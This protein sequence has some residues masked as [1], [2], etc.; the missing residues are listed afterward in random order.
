MELE[1][2][3]QVMARF[4][5][6][7]GATDYRW[8]S[9]KDAI[10]PEIFP[11]CEPLSR[12]SVMTNSF[13]SLVCEQGGHLWLVRTFTQGID[14]VF[15]PIGTLEV[16]SIVSPWSLPRQHWIG[17][18]AVCAQMNER[19]RLAD[20]KFNIL[21]PPPKGEPGTPDEELLTRVRLG[22][23]VTANTRLAL[24]VI[25]TQPWRY[26]GVCFALRS[27]SESS[28]EVLP[29]LAP[30]F[31]INF[32]EVRL[33]S[34]QQA[35]QEAVLMRE[36]APAEWAVLDK[37]NTS[38]VQSALYWS[39]NPSPPVPI[40]SADDPLLDWLFAF[41]KASFQGPELL[42]RLRQDVAPYLLP[43]HLVRMI[44]PEL[45]EKATTLLVAIERGESLTASPEIIEE[46]ARSGYLSLPEVMPLQLWTEHVNRSPVVMEQFVRRFEALE[47]PRSTTLFILD[48]PLSN[49]IADMRFLES[50]EKAAH[51]ADKNGL[52]PPR[53]NV[54]LF[55]K[56]ISNLEH[57]WPLTKIEEL[58]GYWAKSILLMIHKMT[59]PKDGILT[60][61]E[62]LAIAQFRERAF[63]C[64]WV[65]LDILSGL[66]RL[67]RYEEA[68]DFYNF[69][70]EAHSSGLSAK[71]MRIVEAHL[72][73]ADP[74][75]PP[76]IEELKLLAD[77]GLASPEDIILDE[78]SEIDLLACAHIWE[79]TAL[80]ADIIGS[81]EDFL[82]VNLP[83]CPDTWKA[84]I[85]RV[86]TPFYIKRWLEKL[87]DDRLQQAREWVAGIQDIDIKMLAAFCGKG[88]FPENPRDIRALLPWVEALLVSEPRKN[89]LHGLASAASSNIA[90]GDDRFAF[91]LIQALFPEENARAIDFAVYALSGV[92]PLP[93]LV[94]TPPDFVVCLAS[95]ID[96]IALIN[97][98]MGGDDTALSND[99]TV[100]EI[101]FSELCRQGWG[102]PEH[103][104]TA[105]Q[106]SRHLILTNTLSRAPGWE[107]IAPDPMERARYAERLLQ[108]LSLRPEDLSH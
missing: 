100:C 91:D 23:P 47:I 1:V 8:L 14:N 58:Y 16:V 67:D 34:Q 42:V 94:G 43:P 11:V 64:E 83:E 19:E 51:I 49:G 33:S 50:F 5:K 88:I 65:Q 107:C 29:E 10:P 54:S 3:L 38:D 45:S 18:S 40:K 61:A 81:D 72:R 89:R 37:L 84:E 108:S 48:A 20:D 55:L 68:K 103:R 53:N 104:Y 60:P 85:R 102:C 22:L 70:R 93:P 69:L 79:K 4:G 46:L 7:D 52:P 26:R 9:G 6:R 106:L 105:R 30:Y 82:P 73:L 24:S 63:E 98:I 101:L 35:V 12:L 39:A 87:Q 86:V 2:Q 90:S 32:A 36:V 57:L 41:R 62:M 25:G 59:F 80:L 31:C 21:I 95:R 97:A 44:S 78:Q 76:S 99:N 66:L 75:Q 15:R 27:K 13:F 71:A 77:K 17:L 92:G 96:I 56:L 74:S 28:P